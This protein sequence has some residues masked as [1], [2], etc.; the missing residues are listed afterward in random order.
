MKTMYCNLAVLMAKQD[1]PKMQYQVAEALG[2]SKSTINK[3][4][5]GRPFNG[6]VD[7]EIVEK[8]CDYFNCEIGDLFELR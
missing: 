2:A 4:Y 5:H 6:R 8:L 3:L 7:S 1:P